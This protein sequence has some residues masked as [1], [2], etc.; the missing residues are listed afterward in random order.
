MDLNAL[1]EKA[2]QTNASDLHMLA[3][4]SPVYR[5]NGLLQ[6]LTTVAPLTE[7]QLEQMI[8]SLLTPAQKEMFVN[9]RALDFSYGYGGG[10]YGDK[11]RFRVNIYYQ[12][13]TLAAA[14]R[15]LPPKVKTIEELLL[16]DI[17]HKLS[18]L[19]QGFVLIT[20]PTGH[21]KT[22]TIAAI[23]NEINMTR[24][25]NILTIEDPI[26]YVYPKGRSIISQRELGHDTLSWGEG[27]K[28]ALREDPDVVIVGEMRDPESIASAIT[29]AETGHLVLSTL[30]TNSASQTVD[31]IID[32]FPEAQQN[33]VRIQLASTLEAI[34]S[35][36]L[37]PTITAGRVVAT[38]IL[39]ATTAV[40]SNIREGKTHLIDSIIETSSD[41]G[42]NSLES[43]L[44]KLVAD[45]KI[46][47]DTAKAYALRPDSLTRLLGQ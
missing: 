31:R 5:I 18:T 25:A 10:T 43:S 13:S 39:M 29:I 8:F 4:V 16:P 37:I 2:I 19:K 1:L 15:L 6:Q 23:V 30:H 38:E 41:E 44:A 26:E 47:V 11:G 12:R 7:P 22:T 40:R 28:S 9:S 21:G 17:C 42:M 27:L 24:S 45:G 14:F 33:Q 32:S 3:G 20:G 35:Q 36:R 46:A 34:I